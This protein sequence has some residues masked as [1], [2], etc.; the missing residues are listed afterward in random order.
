MLPL[1]YTLEQPFPDSFMFGCIQKSYFG[2]LQVIKMSVK[3]WR[4]GFDIAFNII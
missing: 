2:E 4:N 3:P 1:L